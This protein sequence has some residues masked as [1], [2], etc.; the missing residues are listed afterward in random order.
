MYMHYDRGLIQFNKERG[1]QLEYCLNSCSLNQK[2]M[3]TIST[4]IC[5]LPLQMII[6]RC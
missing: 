3:L 6:K 4:K 2:D 5:N 1:V